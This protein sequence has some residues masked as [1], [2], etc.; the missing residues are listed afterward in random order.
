MSV[1]LFIVAFDLLTNLVKSVPI[2]KKEQ[3]M[4]HKHK[5]MVLIICCKIQSFN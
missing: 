3:L 1:V 2:R 5:T 4:Q